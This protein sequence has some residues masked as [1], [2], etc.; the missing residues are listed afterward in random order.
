[1]H[2]EIG[3]Q[4]ALKRKKRQNAKVIN[5][6][7]PIIVLIATTVYFDINLQYGVITT[8]ICFYSDATILSS[9]ATGCDNYE[10][11]TSQLPYGVMA[12]ILSLIAFIITGI[13]IYGF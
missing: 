5:F 9:S 12:A 1:M 2:L 10:H 13:V 3:L 8:L 6:F 11:A 4:N 7:L